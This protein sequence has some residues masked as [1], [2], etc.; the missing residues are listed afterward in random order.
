MSRFACIRGWPATIYSDPGSQ[1]VGADREIK[2][3]WKGID[4]EALDKDG[5][6]NGLTWF[7]VL[8]TVHG[9]KEKSRH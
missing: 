5:V 8:R 1:L 4:R 7:S 6:Q 9:I 3:A 2:E